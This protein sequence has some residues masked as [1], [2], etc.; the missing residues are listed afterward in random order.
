MKRNNDDP[1]NHKRGQRH[2]AQAYFR[3]LRPA[4]SKVH[5][6]P[7]Q[8]RGEKELPEQFGYDFSFPTEAEQPA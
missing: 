1:K 3:G 6:E 4:K 5:K 2:C 8:K 7:A